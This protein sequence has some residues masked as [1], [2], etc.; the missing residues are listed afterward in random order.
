MF[1][2]HFIF[3]NFL[4]SAVNNFENRSVFEKVV[5]NL[6]RLLFVLLNFIKIVRRVTG[7]AILINCDCSIHCM[8]VC[9]L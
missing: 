3:M 5:I 1:S 9:I 4:I 7:A 8:L 6:F 2:D